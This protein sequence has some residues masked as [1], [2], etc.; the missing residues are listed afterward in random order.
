MLCYKDQ[1]FCSHYVECK[2]GKEC[3]RALTMDVIEEA[4][5]FGMPIERRV[6]QPECFLERIYCAKEDR[7]EDG[8]GETSERPRE[9]SRP[10]EIGFQMKDRRKV[11]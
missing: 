11:A 5:K 6:N 1:W 10:E 3:D 7:I 8:E 2:N 4:S 9:G